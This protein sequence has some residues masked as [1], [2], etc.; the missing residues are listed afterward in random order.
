MT[1]GAF[2]LTETETDTNKQWLVYICVEVFTL[3]RNTDVIR[4]C[5]DFIGL[6]W[7]LF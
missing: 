6:S 3:H 5:G 1:A 2:T 4:Y 7:G